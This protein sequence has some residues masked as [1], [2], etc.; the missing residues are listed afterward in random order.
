MSDNQF[1]SVAYIV[2]IFMNL[3]L[4]SILKLQS[5]LISLNFTVFVTFWAK[6]CSVVQGSES[7]SV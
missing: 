5:V 6:K 1:V 2:E 3:V 4:Y 7:G